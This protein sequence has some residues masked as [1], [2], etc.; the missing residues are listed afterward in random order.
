MK[1]GK[2]WHQPGRNS[3]RG[4]PGRLRSRRPPRPLRLPSLRHHL[5]HRLQRIPPDLLFVGIVELDLLEKKHC[6]RMPEYVFIY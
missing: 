3:G 2:T 4:V 5:L 1:Y 6:N